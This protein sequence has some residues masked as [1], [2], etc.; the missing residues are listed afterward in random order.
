MTLARSGRGMAFREHLLIAISG[1]L[2]VSTTRVNPDGSDLP[3]RGPGQIPRARNPPG[4]L[5]ARGRQGMPCSS[6]CRAAFVF[7]S[8]VS[9]SWGPD[10]DGPGRRPGLARRLLALSTA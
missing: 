4:D 7:R 5:L 9:A 1:R 6:R 3:V 10:P 2:Q 8:E